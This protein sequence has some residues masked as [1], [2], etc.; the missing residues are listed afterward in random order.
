MRWY[1]VTITGR[2]SHAGTT[3]IDRRKDALLAASK[4]FVRLREIAYEHGPYGVTTVGHVDVQPNSRNVIPGEVMFTADVR[5]PEADHLE[6]MGEA[7]RAAVAEACALEGLDSTIDE[8]WYFPP[9]AF[10]AERVAAVRRATEAAG[11]SH[12]DMVS[13][14]GHD[15]CYVAR[16]APTA[17]IFVPCKD[18]L[19]HNEA[20]HAEPEHLIAGCDVLLRAVLERASG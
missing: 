18:G 17:M 16:V 1:N 2:E 19:S 10:D 13:G 5:H 14:A 8:I 20:E 6:A 11:L 3:P 9:V 15:A 12:R 7:F 4:V